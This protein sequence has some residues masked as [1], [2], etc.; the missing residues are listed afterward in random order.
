MILVGSKCDLIKLSGDLN[1]SEQGVI[2]AK[3]INIQYFETSALTGQNVSDAINFLTDTVF[4]KKL[5][6]RDQ[7]QEMP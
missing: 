1:Q 6:D 5:K 4:K 7:M 2:L 3:Q